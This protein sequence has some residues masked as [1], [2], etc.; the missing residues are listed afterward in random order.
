MS[1]TQ[2]HFQQRSFGSLSVI[3]HIKMFKK[4]LFEQKR[5]IINLIVLEVISCCNYSEAI[6]LQQ[7]LRHNLSAYLRLPD[8][9]PC[10]FFF[11]VVVVG[12]LCAQALFL[13]V[14]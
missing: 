8:L 2:R 5:S 6:Q 10:V 4:I 1:T 12:A 9:V 7:H 13:V 14:F 11:L 3:L